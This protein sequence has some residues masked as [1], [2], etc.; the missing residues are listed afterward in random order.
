MGAGNVAQHLFTAFTNAATVQVVQLFLR[1]TTKCPSVFGNVPIT[2][3]PENIGNADVYLMA[4]SDTA[5]PSVSTHLKT[6]KGIVAHTSG[7][8]HINA[9]TA[10]R[11]GVF[12]PLQTFSKSVAVD[13]SEIPICVEASES[14]DEEL[15]MDLG[16]TISNQVYPVN[17]ERREQLHLAAVFV[18]NFTNYLFAIGK[19]LLEAQELPFGILHPLIQETVN[20]LTTVD[21]WEAQTGPARRNDVITMQK[22]LDGLHDPIHKKIYQLL[23]EAIKQH[24]EEKL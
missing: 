24:Y 22:H 3:K 16:N 8:T 23:S 7:A 9:I 17:S 10:E 18:N 15:L 14:K 5:I 13:F 11:K 19:K 4:V 6:K 20:K 12:Y 21:P 2:D 1:D